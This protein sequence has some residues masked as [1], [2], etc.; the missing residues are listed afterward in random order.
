MGARVGPYLGCYHPL[1]FMGSPRP[2][3]RAGFIPS[4][5][6]PFFCRI[7]NNLH[8]TV[9]TT[10]LKCLPINQKQTLPPNTPLQ[11]TPTRNS[12]L[13]ESPPVF[14]FLLKIRPLF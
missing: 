6:L 9:I 7:G 12:A 3:R 1:S 4:V 14:F 2:R 8:Y 10:L 13:I 11:K 5:N